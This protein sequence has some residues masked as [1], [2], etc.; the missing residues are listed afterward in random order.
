MTQQHSGIEHGT[1][2]EK[3][4]HENIIA[5]ITKARSRMTFKHQ[6]E[7]GQK[8][9]LRSPLFLCQDRAAKAHAI[10]DGKEYINFATYDYLDLNTHPE[11][12]AVVT[13][14][15]QRYGTSAGASRV[16]GGE[17]LPHRQLEK[18]LADF[19]DVEDC[20]TYV[21][22]HACNVSTLGFLFSN[23][24]IIFHDELAHNS[25][26]QGARLSGAVR[27]GYQHNDCAALEALLKERRAEGKRACIVT[28]GLFSMDGNI[29]DLPQL[30]A[31][32]KRYDCLL[33]IDEAHSLGVL[34]KTG[35]GIREYYGVA[36]AEVD[37]WMSTLSKTLCGCGGFIAGTHELVDTLKF[38]SPGFVF[39]VGM[40]P[41]VAAAC[42][43]AL[44]LLQREPERVQRIQHISKYF[45]D[46]ARSKGL[47]TGAAQG[48]ATV[49]VIIGKSLMAGFVS[50]AIMERGVYAMPV[51]FPAVK[52]GQARLRF[53]LSA[54]HTEE[55]IR[56]AI[57]IVA[58]EIPRMQARY[59][60]LI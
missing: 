15:A 39:S 17:R 48:Y 26:V 5:A 29:P 13:E 32:K 60:H 2:A 44:E 45:L 52:E 28:E 10:M 19:Y 54:A 3:N 51:S 50:N 30:I 35:R 42:T 33:M 59:G 1:M 36:P 9:G 47:D 23:R 4:S 37:M 41:I 20:I 43:K 11:I 7:L 18:A 16:V 27:V 12:T 55:D 56:T 34:G 46:Y 22:G 38:G 6:L 58:E 24:D 21:S 49:P 25:L 53:F 8:L 14:T 40:P 57:D 31:L